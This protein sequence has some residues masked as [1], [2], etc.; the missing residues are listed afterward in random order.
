MQ[1]QRPVLKQV[2][3]L[4]MTPQ[5]YQA[6]RLMAL[7]L[8]DLRTTIEEELEKNPALQV[9]E[10]R[11]TVSLDALPAREKGEGEVD[12]FDH[13]SDTG[14]S[15]ADAEAASDARRQFIEGA[16]SL[17]ESLQD[18]L[19]WQL[20]LQPI[21]PAWRTVGELVI[22]NLDEN[23]FHR[24]P[25]EILIKEDS[26]KEILPRVIDLIQ[27]FEPLGVCVK[28]VRESLLVQI[29]R[30]PSPHAR[31]EELVEKWFPELEKQKLREIEKGMRISEARLKEIVAFIRTLDPLPGRNYSRDVV[32]YVLPD[33]QVTL[34]DGEFVIIL[35]DEVIPVLGINPLFEEMSGGKGKP[36]DPKTR[37][38]VT[39]TLQ[40]A[41]WFIRTIGQRNETL[42]K[43]C[44]AVV[45]FQREFLL[46]GPKYLK[47]LTLKDIA[48]EIG[49]HEAT[50]SRITSAKYVQTE[51]GIFALKH[52]FSN[53]VAGTGSTGS[54]FSKEGVKE[55]IREIIGQE[56]GGALSDQ[57]IVEMLAAQGVSIARRTV[58]KYRGELAID[59]SYQR[60]RS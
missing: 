25:P 30:H 34:R 58:A 1:S 41:R 44:R 3:K 10:D 11:S 16:L 28:D 40:D 39:Q 22:R 24:E 31:A 19:L 43:V 56:G 32:R 60:R 5:L 50:V 37:Q 13:S 42:L 48:G 18:H 20:E 33:V 59:S 15:R 8:Q 26:D 21:P 51:W 12:Y 7:P 47:P 52:F 17:P 23:G 53:S 45:E 29:R 6:V 35:N 46:K 55:I 54:R 57:K 27:G 14:Y 36:K 38:F 49:V 2:Q 4:K 9:M